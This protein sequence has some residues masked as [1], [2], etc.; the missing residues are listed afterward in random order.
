MNISVIIP[1][2][3]KENR[4]YH[5]VNSVL[6]QTFKDFELIIVD[7]GSTD[8]SVEI[9]QRIHD[10]RIR[11]IRKKN[12]GPSSARNCGVREAKFDWI[13]FLDADDEMVC[14]SLDHFVKLASANP[15]INMFVSNFFHEKN[16]KKSLYSYFHKDGIVSDNFKSWFFCTMMPCQGS[17]LYRKAI[18]LENPYSEILRRYEDAEML[19]S[20]MRTQLIYTSKKPVFTYKLDAAAASKGRKDMNEDYLGHLSLSNKSLWERI[21]VYDLYKQAL[22]LYPKQAND[23][24]NGTFGDMELKLIYRGV[25][26]IKFVLLKISKLLNLISVW[27]QMQ[28]CCKI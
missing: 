10:P 7:D 8:K 23:I 25:K 12:G 17:T 9:V 21:V 27:K 15:K 6:T 20:L 24:Y 16:G 26:M 5:T 4:I 22:R 19:F 28:S 14:D 13:I 2:Y 1:L 11:L 18:L 3:N